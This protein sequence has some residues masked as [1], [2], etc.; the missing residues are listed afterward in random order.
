MKRISLLLITLVLFT[1]CEE[2][3]RYQTNHSKDNVENFT[4]TRSDV[5]INEVSFKSKDLNEF[6]HEADWIELINTSTES[7]VLEAGEWYLSDNP[8]K[9]QKFELPEITIESEEIIVIWCDGLIGHGNDIHSS[10]KLSS[11]GESVNLF[12]QGELK[13]QVFFENISSDVECYARIKNTWT[14]IEKGTLGNP[15]S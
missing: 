3:L 10:F 12:Q 8:K 9:D 4:S 14:Y 13:D 1:S 2:G 5:V 11:K 6:G 7:I 15:N